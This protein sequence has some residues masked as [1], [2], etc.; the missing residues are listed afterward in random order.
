M[1]E[2]NLVLR[3]HAFESR[4]GSSVGDDLDRVDPDKVRRRFQIKAVRFRDFRGLVVA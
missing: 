3:R 2:S 1:M 4:N